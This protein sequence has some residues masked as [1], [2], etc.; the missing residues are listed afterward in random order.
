MHRL[1]N[2]AVR[3]GALIALVGAA[4]CASPRPAGAPPPAPEPAASSRN[5]WATDAVWYQIFPERF[6]NGDPG[7]DPT[8]ESLE[9]PDVV[10]R[11]W[12]VS[13]WTDDW[14]SRAP[15][16][17]ALGS[18]FYED[19]VFHRRYGGDLQGV[20]EKLDYFS[21]LG[22]NAIYFNPL[23]YA[24]SLH[25]YD[26][27]T[28]H[29]VDPHFG[30]DPAADFALMAKE[31]SDPTTWLWTSADKLLLEIVAKAHA[32]GIRVILDGVFNHTGRDFFAFADLRKNQGASLYRDWYMVESF[33]DPKTP[34]NEFRYKG[35]W[36]IDTLPEFADTPDGKDLHP[37]PKRYV[38]DAT[39]RW[40]DPDGDGNSSDG[41]DGWRL[42]VANEVPIAF[43]ADW[44]VHVRR[45]N[46]QAYTVVEIWNEAST[47]VQQGGFSASMNYHGFAFPV[48][49]FLIDGAMTAPSFSSELEVRRKAHPEAVQHVLQNLID[50]HDTDRLASMIVNAGR[51]PYAKADRFDYDV[52]DRS[53]P[54]HANRYEVRKPDAKERRLQRLVVLFQMTYVGA[55]MIYYGTEAGM[56]GGDD[57]DDRMPMVWSDL[58]Y[59]PQA[60]DPLGRPRQPDA[61][62]FD[63]D[64]FKFYQEVIA[65]RRTHASLR[66]GDFH[67]LGVDAA[68]ATIAFARI[69]EN[70]TLIVAINR[71]D[72]PQKIKL[73]RGAPQLAAV[74][75]L[76]PRFSS[77]ERLAE[78]EVD[79]DVETFQILVPGLCGMVFEARG[80][81]R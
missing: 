27:N 52:G 34:Q 50:S 64:L 35:W 72:S 46:P 69:H 54:R 44:N 76:V 3:H 21:E 43:W 31:S 29:H 66:R 81:V 23:F 58:T 22:I 62:A 15:W 39:A 37:G 55:P 9:F 12:A 48:K 71:S 79:K 13:A 11:T 4:S 65:L 60:A 42:D 51:Q 49:G 56:W 77:S 38:F 63:N 59:E 32:R 17:V 47:F 6:R 78:A 73:S 1:L 45:L 16:E 74:E 8:H 28:Y 41:V 20:L 68:Q 25:K 5:D 24:R 2:N 53:S 57:P 26:G 7:N 33:D 75:S 40:M 14:Y 67:T 30:P 61:V 18:R 80:A 19:G 36:G 70:E 10:P